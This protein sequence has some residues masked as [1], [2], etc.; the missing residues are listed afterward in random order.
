MNKQQWLRD[1]VSRRRFVQAT[2][3]TFAGGSAV[4]LAA[5]GG[6]DDGATTSVSTMGATSGTGGDIAILNG[7]LGLEHPAVFA[8]TAGA[9]LLSGDALAVGKQFLEQEQEHADGLA[10]AI[11]QLGGMPVKPK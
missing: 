9:P 7:A 6:S 3:V 8:Y 2:G 10:K 4:F 1:P 5:C 11:T